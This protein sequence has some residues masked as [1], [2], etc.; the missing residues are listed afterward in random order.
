MT[1]EVCLNYR[2]YLTDDIQ[3]KDE[4]GNVVIKPRLTG[5]TPMNYFSRFRTMM[6]DAKKQGYFQQNPAEDIKS[7]MGR[8]NKP[9]DT[10]T[11]EEFEILGTVPCPNPYV[12]QAFLFCMLTGIRGEAARAL[13]WEDINIEEEYMS[14]IQ[15]KTGKKVDVPLLEQA[16]RFI[17]KR[18]GEDKEKVT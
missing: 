16:V 1:E 14:V 4:D 7:K 8:E 9:K 12:K 13:T 10:L 17:P 3:V 6:G 2:H 15:G 18:R 11:Y 5:E